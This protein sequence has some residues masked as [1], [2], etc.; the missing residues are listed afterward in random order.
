[1]TNESGLDLRLVRSKERDYL[2]YLGLDLLWNMHEYLDLGLQ[3]G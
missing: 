3:A 1:M 2:Y